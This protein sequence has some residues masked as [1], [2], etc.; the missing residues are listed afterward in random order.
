MKNNQHF[1]LLIVLIFSLAIYVSLPLIIPT[2]LT[3]PRI[4]YSDDEQPKKENSQKTT[5]VYPVPPIPNTPPTPQEIQQSPN[6]LEKSERTLQPKNGVTGQN[7]NATMNINQA[8]LQQLDAVKGIGE[9]KSQAI[10]DYIATHGPITNM[11]QLLDVQGIGPEILNT[12][13]EYFT[14]N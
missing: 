10:L 7:S 12:L 1:Y 8:T 2:Y 11:D 9:M 13:K 6:P 4:V 5:P 3:E 14:A